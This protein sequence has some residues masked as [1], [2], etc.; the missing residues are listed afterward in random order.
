LE[1]R[2]V[3]TGRHGAREAAALTVAVAHRVDQIDLAER[4]HDQR[5]GNHALGPLMRVAEGH[6]RQVEQN[7]LDWR[8]RQASARRTIACLSFQPC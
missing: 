3:R 7:G 1:T 6:H 8:A 5:T 2:D 4:R